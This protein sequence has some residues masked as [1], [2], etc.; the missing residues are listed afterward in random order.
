ME[1]Q[2]EREQLKQELAK[3]QVS[4]TRSNDNAKQ[5]ELEKLSDALE[6]TRRQANE[7]NRLK[8]E[9]THLK[10]ELDNLMKEKDKLESMLNKQNTLTRL[11]S[12]DTD[13]TKRH[14][15]EK[16]LLTSQLEAVARERRQLDRLLAEKE[17]ARQRLE[18]ENEALKKTVEMSKGKGSAHVASA[19]WH[20]EKSALKNELS[21]VYM[22]HQKD[23]EK[24]DKLK[25]ENVKLSRDIEQMR[26]EL[27][28]KTQEL[29]EMKKHTG[30]PEKKLRRDVS[31]SFAQPEQEPVV[32]KSP[33]K[34]S[35]AKESIAVANKHHEKEK[36]V[37][38][39]S[40][41]SI[42]NNPF[43]ALDK[44]RSKSFDDIDDVKRRRNPFVA[45]DRERTQVEK[46]STYN[47]PQQQP[48]K[49]RSE[50]SLL[51]DD[52]RASMDDLDKAGTWEDDDEVKRRERG[53]P[54]KDFVNKLRANFEDVRVSPKKKSQKE[55]RPKVDLYT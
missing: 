6:E 13:D 34:S 55:K 41:Q 7:I 51:S 43:L 42:S 19:S 44:E 4:A 46:E 33:R 10:G 32:V 53:A 14:K 36:G 15:Y 25:T 5:G 30:K 20:D 27:Q 39:L 38:D 28:S 29:N 2:I 12:I 50:F 54:S 47:S 35:K 1:N 16:D 49:H 8:E 17:D 24:I 45:P 26:R 48:L 40:L 18:N 31:L 23:L 11:S 37:D 9:S 3:L 52:F 22:N 21:E